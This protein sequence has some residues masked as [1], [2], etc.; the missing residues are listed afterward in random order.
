MISVLT[1]VPKLLL[2]HRVL[3]P[4]ATAAC[5]LFSTF[6]I[7]LTAAIELS[8]VFNSISSDKGCFFRY[9]QILHRIHQRAMQIT[10]CIFKTFHCINIKWRDQGSPHVWSFI[11]FKCSMM[12]FRKT[13]LSS[14]AT[15]NTLYLL[16]VFLSPIF[17]R[18]PYFST[19]HSDFIL[20]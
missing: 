10:D 14:S 11:S 5:F 18:M 12:K 2:N 3:F 4:L 6:E 9:T 17:V 13:H 1:L 15:Y 16:Y 19:N 8:A 20:T 7:G